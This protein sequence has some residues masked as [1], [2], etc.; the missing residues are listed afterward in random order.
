MM[1]KIQFWCALEETDVLF[2]MMM[3][4]ED[5]S[6]VMDASLMPVKRIARV[7]RVLKAQARV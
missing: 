1:F 4:I 6:P 3:G 5:R 7:R 2:T